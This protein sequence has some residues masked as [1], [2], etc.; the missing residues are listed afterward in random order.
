MIVSPPIINEGTIYF[1]SSDT[2]VYAVAANTG[3]LKWKYSTGWGIV[4]TPTLSDDTVFVGSLDHHIYALN[5]DD[6]ELLWSFNTNA[7]IHSAPIAYGE[8]VFFGSD[9]GWYYAVNK[10]DGDAVW[11]FASNNT[12]DDDIYNYIMTPVVGNTIA[13]SGSVYI[14]TNGNIYRFNAQTFEPEIIEEKTEK[15]PTETILYI[16]IAVSYT[17]LTLPTN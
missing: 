7:A 14:S 3:D 17:H 16:A 6:G 4:T 5:S 12:I 2:H 1:G 8:Y 10:S 15:I 9:D 11:S 13:K